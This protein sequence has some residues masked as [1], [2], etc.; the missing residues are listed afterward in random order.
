MHVTSSF[1]LYL[2][3]LRNAVCT[4]IDFELTGRVCKHIIA[5]QIFRTSQIAAA[6][7]AA[8]IQALNKIGTVVLTC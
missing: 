3:P 6:L 4:C 8:N 5:T 2:S 1:C 7:T